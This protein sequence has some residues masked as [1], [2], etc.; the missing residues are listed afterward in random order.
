MKPTLRTCGDYVNIHESKEHIRKILER[1]KLE[2]T[3]R[4]AV[5]FVLRMQ[6]LIN[7]NL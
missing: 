4:D 6:N 1:C 7:Q 3:G 2:N 5:K